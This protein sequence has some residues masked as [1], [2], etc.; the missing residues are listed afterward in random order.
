[1][2]GALAWVAGRGNKRARTIRIL[3][4]S[5]L[6]SNELL[7]YGYAVGQG[8]GGRFPEGLPLQMCDLTLWLTVVALLT[9]SRRVYEV[10]YFWGLTGSVMAVL[11]PDLWAAFPSYPAAHFFLEHGGVVAGILFLA[12]SRQAR[13]GAGSALRAFGWANVY[14]ASIAVFDAFF[15]TNYFYLCQKPI[16]ASLLDYF[17]PWPW[18]VAVGDV[19]ALVLF[20][21]LSLP[22]SVDFA[23]HKS[24]VE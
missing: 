7:W 14:L 21:L 15:H 19:F 16:H 22:Y 8:W 20:V 18:Y 17:G 1:V 2:A 6:A 24:S 4:G 9:L 3:W 12:W 23:F 11:T 10:A 5:F 13:P